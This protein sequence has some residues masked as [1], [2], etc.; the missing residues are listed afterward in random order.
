MIAFVETHLNGRIKDLYYGSMTSQG[1]TATGHRFPARK[2]YII[3][4]WI[5]KGI[6]LV[7]NHTGSCL[8][9]LNLILFKESY[10]K[11]G[12]ALVMMTVL[13]VYTV[14]EAHIISVYI[15]RNY[16][17]FLMGMYASDM[18]GLGS[19]REEY[20]WRYIG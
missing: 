12:M 17:L 9:V 5:C 20:F 14:V 13:A 4:T 16:I 3:L 15:G 11:D 7:R 1:T 2:V 19:D 6:L 10:R 8:C 18:L